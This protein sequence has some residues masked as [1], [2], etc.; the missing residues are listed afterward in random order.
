MNL[1]PI[2]YT[3]PQ[4]TIQS[5]LSMRNNLTPKM[6]YTGL[7]GKG[8]YDNLKGAY[9][10]LVIFMDAQGRRLFHVAFFR[11][12]LFPA[13]LLLDRLMMTT[14]HVTNPEITKINESKTFTPKVLG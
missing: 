12:R 1:S 7:V 9:K 6:G 3:K 13:A 11:R 4:L 8:T 14:N 10:I 5:S 2:F